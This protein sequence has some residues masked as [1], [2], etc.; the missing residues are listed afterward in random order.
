MAALLPPKVQELFNLPQKDTDGQKEEKAGEKNREEDKKINVGLV[1]SQ[2]EQTLRLFVSRGPHASQGDVEAAGFEG[3]HLVGEGNDHT[4]P[5]ATNNQDGLRF[6]HGDVGDEA[7]G[8]LFSEFPLSSRRFGLQL[9]RVVGQ[10]GTSQAGRGVGEHLDGGRRRIF[11]PAGCPTIP[12]FFLDLN[13]VNSSVAVHVYDEGVV[14]VGHVDLHLAKC[15][16]D[17][18]ADV[19]VGELWLCSEK[20]GPSF[21]Q[22][23]NG[24][25]VEA[26]GLGGGVEAALRVHVE[27]TVALAAVHRRPVERV[28]ALSTLNKEHN[29]HRRV[30]RS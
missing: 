8:P 30:K 27:L 3:V 18:D 7:F 23:P 24:G 29:T 14:G 28:F 11:V 6:P 17:G 9:Q 21:G 2:K 12:G 20:H 10:H 5:D 15:N 16:I 26:V 1:L 19:H 25:I 13:S 22:V 4:V